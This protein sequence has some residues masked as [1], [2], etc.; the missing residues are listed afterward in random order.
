MIRF[1]EELPGPKRRSRREAELEK[2]ARLSH[3]ALVAYEKK[4]RKQ[5]VYRTLDGQAPQ[6]KPKVWASIQVQDDEE[7]P[8]IEESELTSLASD[9]RHSSSP[10]NPSTVQWDHFDGL[11]PQHLPRYVRELIVESLSRSW[12]KALPHSSTMDMRRSVA[13]LMVGNPIVL[14]GFM[15]V[16]PYTSTRPL[17]EVMDRR[18][19]MHRG[20][21]IRMLREEIGASGEELLSD[22]TILCIFIFVIMHGRIRTTPPYVSPYQE[23]PLAVR[24]QRTQ[25]RASIDWTQD[26]PHLDALNIA[27]ARRGGLRGIHDAMLAGWVSYTDLWLSSI[28]WSRPLIWRA[29]YIDDT[30]AEFDKLELQTACCSSPL[31]SGFQ[32]SLAPD[33]SLL[34]G[35]RMA[36]TVTTFL[37]K[38]TRKEQY[39]SSWDTLLKGRDLVQHVLLEE[40]R[41]PWLYLPDYTIDIFD[42]ESIAHRY[43]IHIAA[44]IY[45][46]LVLFPTLPEPQ[47]RP[48]LSARLRSALMAIDPAVEF[49]DRDITLWVTV[50]GSIAASETDRYWWIRRLRGLLIGRFDNV[51]ASDFYE[52][53]S[54]LIQFLWWDFV[55]LPRVLDVWEGVF[56][57]DPQ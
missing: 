29:G 24:Q 51:V 39:D 9:S 31:A 14:H 48:R 27:I 54:E 43:L 52:V 35:L 53:R 46:D 37:D 18:I 47:T 10:A 5:S 7:P 44:L 45:Q 55:C 13:Q 1:C 41:N 11:A 21:M 6:R 15:T 16:M 25:I 38:W 42:S 17:D 22:I 56:S 40:V 2:S 12:P 4:R 8:E 50:M 28:D 26:N 23:T 20:Q 19:M 36:A 32:R 49:F 30:Q 33:D 34:K 57:G 3:A